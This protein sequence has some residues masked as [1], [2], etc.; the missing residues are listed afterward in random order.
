MRRGPAVLVLGAALAGLFVPT[1][2]ISARPVLPTRVARPPIVWRPIPFGERRRSEMGAYSRRHY[3]AWTWRLRR[4]K[5]IVEHY[6]DGTTFSGA[7]ATFAANTV[8]LG[9]LPGVCTHFVI[10]TDGTI[11]QL[12]NL[13]VRC[14]HAIGLNWTAIG[15]E[16]V[17]T[18]DRQILSNPRM[19][20]A[21]LRLTV[22]LM[23]R[24]AIQARNVIGHAETLMSPFH[25]EAYPSWRCQTHA[26][27][28]HVDM[29]V[30]RERLRRLARRTGVPVG[31]P[32][33][34][35]DPHC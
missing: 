27:W 30:Y 10:D 31:P 33:A 7:W 29:Q 25:H 15:I 5:A 8:H 14:R 35:V 13:H 6:T 12:A 22:W 34:W 9:E 2:V 17:G 11:F 18:S 32:P 24:F 21:S 20:R 23:D 16:H 28:Q 26:D 19:M 1:T 4:P 3:G